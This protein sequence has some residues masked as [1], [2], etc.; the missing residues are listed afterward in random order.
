VRWFVVIQPGC[1]VSAPDVFAI[2]FDPTDVAFSL[3]HWGVKYIVDRGVS[4]DFLRLAEVGDVF[5]FDRE[6]VVMRVGRN[7][8][9]D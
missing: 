6:R 3:S 4:V 5:P 9:E 2:F 8:G 7:W 1:D